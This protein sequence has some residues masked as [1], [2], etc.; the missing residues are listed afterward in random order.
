MIGK[1]NINKFVNNMNKD[2]RY[3]KKKNFILNKKYKNKWKRYKNCKMKKDS[4]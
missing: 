2:W 1:I 4:F 3:T